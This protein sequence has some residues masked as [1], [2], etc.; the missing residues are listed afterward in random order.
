MLRRVAGVYLRDEDGYG[1]RPNIGMRGA[2]ADRSAKI[3]LMEDGVLIA[4]APYSAP[5]AYYVPLVTR[6]S[7]SR[8][9]QG[10]VGDSLRPEHRRRRDRLISEPIPASASGYVDLAVGSD[11]YGKLHARAAERRKHWGVMAEYV[12]LRTDGF[13]ELD[14][15][16]PT[17]FDKNDVQLTGAHHV[18]AERRRRITSSSC[19]SATAPRPRTRRT[20]A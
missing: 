14:G 17:G 4:P 9:H 10:P 15:G 20:P 18:G 3:T 16:G 12:K 1:L 8:G 19:A 6:M 13:K 11:L 2:A 5:A 7:S